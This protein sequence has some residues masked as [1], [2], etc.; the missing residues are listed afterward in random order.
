MP[1]YANDLGTLNGD[2]SMSDDLADIGAA[3]HPAVI[4]QIAHKARAQGSRSMPLSTMMSK[5]PGAPDR[6][7]RLQPIGFGTLSFSATS[8]SSLTFTAAPQRP[9]R[10]R[11]MVIDIARNGATATGLITI[12]QVLVGTANQLVGSK[13]I[14]AGAFA[15]TAFDTNVFFNGST[16]GIELEVQLLNSFTPTAPDTIDTNVTMFGDSVG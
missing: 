14:S 7:L 4:R 9:F 1:T 15:P 16:P 5:I 8:G 12:A 6:G 10:P 11:R 13:A 3:L 2:D